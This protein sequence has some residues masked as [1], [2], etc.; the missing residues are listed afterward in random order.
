LAQRRKYEL[1]KRAE[2][3]EET[4]RRITEATVELHGTVGPAATKISEIARRAGVER[5]TVYNHFPD[6]TSL[7]TACSQHWQALHPAPDPS[8]WLAI[9]D[10]GE[11]LRTGLGKLYALYR[12]T[13]P[14]MANL[15]RDAESLPA[16]KAVLDGGL[17]AY[18]E[19]V[20][21]ILTAPFQ[22]EGRTGERVKAAAGAATSFHLWRS[23]SELGDEEAADLAANLV[24]AAAGGCGSLLSVDGRSRSDG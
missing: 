16:L 20:R 12:E 8:T 14:M 21:G 3:L 2:R 9:P 11:R 1:K 19:A 17:G 4:R 15:Q 7:L 10:P 24:E 23:L 13:A 5:V 22:A 6:D 18:L